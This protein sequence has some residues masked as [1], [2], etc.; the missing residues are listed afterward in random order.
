MSNLGKSGKIILAS[1]VLSAIS[2]IAVKLT[3][4]LFSMA[5]KPT[6]EEFV[7]IRLEQIEEESLTNM[8]YV[9]DNIENLIKEQERVMN[10]KHF[11]IPY[12]RFT[13]RDSLI[14]AISGALYEQN[15][16]TIY[17]FP[18]Q[19]MDK[20]KILAHELGHFYSDKLS[21]EIGN[22][23]WPLN[24]KKT[25]EDDKWKGKKLISEGIAIYFAKKTLKDTTEDIGREIVNFNDYY[26]GGGI[27][28]F[29]EV[30][31][32]VIRS[33]LDKY[34]K[35]GIEYLIKNPPN[36]KQ[37]DNIKEYREKCLR[38]LEKI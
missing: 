15:G 14:S 38:G 7:K 5:S 3:I 34:G 10:I 20:K 33:V 13:Y 9:R 32:H 35:K 6:L 1:S 22:G 2:I 28:S 24:N 37:L 21:E 8:T 26:E 19:G 18:T 27:F 30:G 17:F 16:D 36:K 25:Q 29:Y 31:Y 23:N 11:G 4:D 12:F